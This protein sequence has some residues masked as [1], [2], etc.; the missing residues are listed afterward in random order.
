[1][2]KILNSSILLF[3][4][5]G[6]AIVFRFYNF[7]LRYS[8]GEE[9]VRDAVIGIEGARELQLPL[10]GSFSS[11]GPFT[12]GPWY[13]YQLTLFTLLIRNNYAPW[14]YLSVISVLYVLIMYKIGM[15]IKGKYFGLLLALFSAFS[16]A[17]VISATHLT[18]HNNTSIFAV[19][20]IL[21]FI[22]LHLKKIV[23][24]WWGFA[25][26]IVIGI[27]SNL[28]Y[29]ILSLAILPIIL[30]V[31][32]P[33]KYLYFVTFVAGMFVAFIPMLIFELNNHWFNTKNII[34]YL[35]VDRHRV[36]V[37]NSW[38]IYLRDFW[39]A[40][41]ADSLGVPVWVAIVLIVSFL[42]CCLL[43][44]YRRRMS[45]LFFLIF[46]AFFFDFVFLRYYWGPRFFGYLNFLRPFVF[47]ATAYAVFALIEL[48][49][50]IIGRLLCF[51]AAVL[52]VFLSFPRNLSQLTPDPFSQQIYQAVSEVEKKYPNEKFSVYS[53]SDK[54]RGSYNALVY[55]I[56][57][58]FDKDNRFDINGHK[59][60]IA[61]RCPNKPGSFN[62][63]SEDGIMLDLDSASNSALVK[64]GWNKVSF[65]T[66]YESHARWWF[67]E[68]P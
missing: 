60:G 50:K 15:L 39:P 53:C 22:L 32:R 14:I 12:F 17:Q 34:H 11:L 28:H 64:A 23:S 61:G 68:Q 5:I 45:I 62:V 51:V 42:A 35:L 16:P 13:A 26:G 38:T 9:T 24:Y 59:V 40:F 49:P 21:L 37:P 4:I 7:P 65:A 18:S 54:Y 67:K 29:Q 25:L 2:N 6:A 41:W 30:F 66:I 56:I 48:K 52:I 20:T 1:M 57:F 43:A 10:T 19:L 8:L 3:L 27:G 33:K 47:I 58:A 46:V 63:I 44:F 31:S 36:F 55:A